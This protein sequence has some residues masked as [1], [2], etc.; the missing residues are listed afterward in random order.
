MKQDVITSDGQ[1]LKLPVFYDYISHYL[2]NVLNNFFLLSSNI[3]TLFILHFV[4]YILYIMLMKKQILY[5]DIHVC[6]IFECKY[7]QILF[8]TSTTDT[9]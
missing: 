4:N 9:I 2:G 8:S 1:P 5:F 7:L 3:F 6:N